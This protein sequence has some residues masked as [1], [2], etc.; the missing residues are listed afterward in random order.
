MIVKIIIGSSNWNDFVIIMKK[1]YGFF[2]LWKHF[3]SLVKFFNQG[4]KRTIGF[5]LVVCGVQCEKI[6]FNI[7]ET[8]KQQFETV[9][10]VS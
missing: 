8:Q 9:L 3:L 7:F 2:I 6:L 5:E 10:N 4:R 1:I